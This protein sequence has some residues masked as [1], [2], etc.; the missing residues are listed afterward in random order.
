MSRCLL[1]LWAAALVA[2]QE[3][4]KNPRTSPADVAQGQKTFRSHC[5]PCHGVNAEGGLGPNL[6]TGTFYHG[7]T[8]ADL[9]RNIANGIE[10]TE[11]PGLFYSPDRIWQVI[12]YLRSLNG[13]AQLTPAAPARGETLFQ[14]SGCAQCHRINGAGGRMGPDLSAIGM[15][16]SAAYLRQSILEP[17]ADVRRRYWV[18]T[19]TDSAGKTVEGFLMNEDT[20]TIQFIDM[21][22]HLYS[23]AKA[24][25]HS[26]RI[27][28][29]SKMP[30][31]QGKLSESEVNDLVAYLSSLRPKTGGGQ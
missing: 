4:V 1:F 31:Y 30:S 27:D 24:D 9:L 28:R 15:A 19:V 26:Y 25:L 22:G 23:V 11:M 18:A 5:A 17:N 13:G 6:S 16:R 7:S 8:D 12:A 21:A 3:E 2:Q 29:T 20:Y 14:R 10:G